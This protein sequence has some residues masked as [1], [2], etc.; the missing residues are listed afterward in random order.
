VFTIRKGMNI[1]Q[2]LERIRNK[3]HVQIVVLIN[4]IKTIQCKF[5]DIIK[6]LATFKLECVISDM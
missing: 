3:N 2:S 5:T 6:Q 1:N 4:T